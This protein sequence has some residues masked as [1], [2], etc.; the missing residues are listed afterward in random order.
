MRGALGSHLNDPR[1][2]VDIIVDGGIE[3]TASV[4]LAATGMD[5]RRLDM[6]G[7]DELL[8]RGVYYGA[9]RSEAAQ[10]GGDPVVV[11]GAGNSAG[12]AV[13]NL[14]YAGARV[15]MLVRGDWLG[16]TMS[17]YLVQRIEGNPLID[18]RLN[19]ELTSM[20]VALIFQR[21]GELGV[22]VQSKPRRAPS[23]PRPSAGARRSARSPCRSGARR[24]SS[25]A[26]RRRGRRAASPSRRG[27]RGSPCAA[28]RAALGR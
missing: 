21:P 13:L 24:R 3:I 7:L 2:R 22:T 5:W 14:A 11:V 16:K 18:V 15:T 6:P 9:G 12:Q 4:V 28:R 10:C 19:T 27:C 25:T 8:G 1:K 23:A 26:P 17:A 20:A